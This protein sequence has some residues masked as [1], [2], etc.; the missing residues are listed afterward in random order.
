MTEIRA[1][2]SAILQ[3][4]YALLDVEHWLMAEEAQLVTLRGEEAVAEV[5]LVREAGKLN[6]PEFPGPGLFMVQPP[7]SFAAMAEA[8]SNSFRY[9][10]SKAPVAV[11]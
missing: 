7:M 8:A 4:R 1:F 2:E 11:V 3:R 6:N 5:E 10:P 9:N